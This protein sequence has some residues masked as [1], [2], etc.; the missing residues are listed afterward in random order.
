MPRLWMVPPETLC[1]QHLL[2]EHHESHMFVGN[3]KLRRRFDGYISGNHFSLGDLHARHEALA[4]EL[5]RRNRNHSSPFP[6]AET[7]KFLGFYLPPHG[8]IDR[9]SA[10]EELYSRC[11]DCNHRRQTT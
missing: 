4:A 9:D 3:L 10:A 2:G 6:S 1:L 11:P 5:I 7:V 8:P